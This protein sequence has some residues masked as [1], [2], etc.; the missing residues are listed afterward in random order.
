MKDKYKSK[1]HFIKSMK[2]IIHNDFND[3][4]S[5]LNMF[6]A[7]EN[8]TLSCIIT[9]DYFT[10]ERI[11]AFEKYKGVLPKRGYIMLQN[12]QVNLNIF[13]KIIDDE[14]LNHINSFFY[15]KINI[16]PCEYEHFLLAVHH[17]QYFKESGLSTHKSK[18][19][20]GIKQLKKMADELQYY[21]KESIEIILPRL[22]HFT[23]SHFMCSSDSDEIVKR[24]FYKYFYS[25]I[26]KRIPK[27]DT[28]I[29][30]YDEASKDYIKNIHTNMW[31]E[32]FK[33]KAHKATTVLSR[34][35]KDC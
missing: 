24:Y 17:I 2:E 9:K 7:L 4:L 28:L 35:K 30:T 25:N 20:K 12:Q 29:S 8:K 31:E 11:F 18:Y 5:C 33:Y 21:S 10:V 19:D 1:E 26:N 34:L 3:L 23:L 6:N 14:V 15:E 27:N 22:P 16:E 32:F 13:E